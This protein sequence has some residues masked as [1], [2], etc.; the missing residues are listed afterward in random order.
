MAAW[1]ANL[2]LIGS[3][4]WRCHG[5]GFVGGGVMAVKSN[6]ELLDGSIITE[7]TAIQGSGMRAGLGRTCLHRSLRHRPLLATVAEGSV[8]KES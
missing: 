4:V 5:P 6:V 3:H 7:C 1:K 2:T 8:A